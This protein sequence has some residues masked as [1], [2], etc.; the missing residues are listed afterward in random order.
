MQCD[1]ALEENKAKELLIKNGIKLSPLSS[2]VHDCERALFPPNTYV[3]GY[4]DMTISQIYEGV[5]L[6]S[7]AWEKYL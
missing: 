1:V 5:E 2:S 3:V 6:W 7:A 4:G